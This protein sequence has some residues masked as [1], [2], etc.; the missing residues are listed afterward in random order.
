MELYRNELGA[1]SRQRRT[2]AVSS[3]IPSSLSKTTSG[4][5]VAL[6]AL[7]FRCCKGVPFI[8]VRVFKTWPMPSGLACR[9]ESAADQTNAFTRNA[10]QTH[11][12]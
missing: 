9:R 1:Q 12:G 3:A 4:G 10:L 8:E 7:G 6:C 2:G 11:W 5:G